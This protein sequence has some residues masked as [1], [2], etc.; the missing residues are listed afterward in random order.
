[1]RKTTTDSVVA[2]VRPAAEATREHDQTVRQIRDLATFPSENPNPVL[3]VSGDGAVLYAN[4]AAHALD[5]LLEGADGGALCEALASAVS[6]AFRA[7]ECG[8]AEFICKDRVYVFALTPVSGKSYVNLYGRDVTDER[9]ANEKVIEVKNFNENIL[10]NLSNGVITLDR[11][12]L[13]TKTNPAAQRILRMPDEDLIG[14][15][16]SE[17]FTGRNDWVTE[18]IAK[19]IADSNLGVW[20]DK[21]IHFGRHEWVS[22]NVTI[23]PLTNVDQTTIGY[24]LILEDI[25]REKRIKSTMV[26]FMSDKVVDRLLEADEALLGG[27]SQEV[28]ILFSD[29]REFT[30]LSEKLGA[31]E[32]VSVLNDYF[33]GMVDVIFDHDGTL[34]KF[35]GDAI[36]AVFGAPFVSADDTDNAVTTAI[37]MLIQLERFN[38]DRAVE[39]KPSLDIGIGID[40]GLVIAGTIGSPK[41]MDYTVIGDHVNVAARIESA[42]KYYGTKILISENTL[43]HLRKKYRLREIDRVL[44]EGRDVPVT[45]FEILDFHSDESFPNMDAVLVAFEAGLQHYRLREWDKGAPCFAEAL[46]GNPRDRPT[47]IFLDRCWTYLARPPGDSW[48]GATAITALSK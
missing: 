24:M 19:V 14:R 27:T 45:L 43:G 29:I 1:M 36:M 37:E 42:N 15:P 3:R 35:I 20:L 33:A 23:V 13:I 41:R 8:E 30:N 25:T 28:T 39:E 44:V 22:V 6:A 5:G 7:A 16:V 12:Q 10:Q 11:S 34:D 40:T 32:M 26:R 9:R 47:Q 18:S 46:K 17:I 48:T 2:D 31:R 38:R 21:A 4:E